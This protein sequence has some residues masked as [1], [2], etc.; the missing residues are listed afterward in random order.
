[1]LTRNVVLIVAVATA[2]LFSSATAARGLRKTRHEAMSI[3]QPPSIAGPN[4]NA[5][6]NQTAPAAVE[7]AVQQAQA[8]VQFQ[9]QTKS[10]TQTENQTQSQP[11]PQTQPPAQSSQ[12][13]QQQQNQSAAEGQAQVEAQAQTEA[14]PKVQ[15]QN[16]EQNHTQDQTKAEPLVP[17]ACGAIPRSSVDLHAADVAQQGTE[18]LDYKYSPVD[19]VH[20]DNTGENA[21]VN[22][23]FGSL[24]LPDG[25]YRVNQLQFYFP[26]EHEINGKPAA[27]EI[28]VIH[29]KMGEAGKPAAN[30]LAVLVILLQERGLKQEFD[31]T[32]ELAFLQNLGFSGMLPRP[33]EKRPVQDAVDIAGS[34]DQELAGGFYHYKSALTTG[35]CSESV[36][37]FVL[38]EP[39][40]VSSDMVR[41]YRAVFPAG[42]AAARATAHGEVVENLLS[43]AGEY[44]FVQKSSAATLTLAS[45]FFILGIAL[46]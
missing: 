29:Q 45:S 46:Q 34:F 25:E 16:Q 44:K 26:S 41:H 35:K 23:A 10:Q 20:L 9:G 38:K 6:A 42:G 32:K 7:P 13:S 3:Q 30:G 33:G 24:K 5:N 28:H 36:H 8:Q 12:A 18:K 39:A 21:R 43:V 40:A 31:R 11:Q 17:E 15:D 4:A 22:G 2:S 19:N 1:M 27:G 37:W 14:Q